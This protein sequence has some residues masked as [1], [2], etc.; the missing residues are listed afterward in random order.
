MAE[1]FGVDTSPTQNGPNTAAL[2]NP[3]APPPAASPTRSN[4]SPQVSG[5]PQGLS[6]FPLGLNAG[7][8][9]NSTTQPSPNTASRLEAIQQ[10]M[11]MLQ[12]MMG[13]SFPFAAQA[14]SPAASPLAF[15]QMGQATG[16]ST[17]FSQMGQATGQSTGFPQMGQGLFPFG[18]AQAMGSN[19]FQMMG[20]VPPF[21]APAPAPDANASEPPSVRFHEQLQTLREMGF[22]NEELNQR[23]LLAA[24]GNTEAAI[25]YLLEH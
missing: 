21:A 3:W 24:G 4:A 5:F 17:G 22:S 10:Q 14:G 13:G 9:T 12:S 16:Q 23:A 8:H 1:R 7:Q 20:L 25:A 19:P 18:S 15:P 11:Q 6:G 2:P